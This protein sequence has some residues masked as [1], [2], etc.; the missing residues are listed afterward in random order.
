MQG[1]SST[2]QPENDDSVCDRGHQGA[3][4]GL[5]EV[6]AHAGDIPDIVANVVCDHR[7]ITR[8]ILRNARLDL[9]NQIRPDI[10]GL[11][12]DAATDASEQG[13]RRSAEPDGGNDRH[14]VIAVEH[15]AEEPD[16]EREPEQTETGDRKAHHRPTAER[17]GE[18]QGNAALARRLRGAGIGGGSDPHPDETCQSGEER[19]KH[20]G[21]RT[22]R[23]APR[24]EDDDQ[25]RHQSDEDGDGKVLAAQERHR[26][27]AN[28]A[29]Q[30]DHL[31]V[32]RVGR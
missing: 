24:E 32:S 23:P 8:V 7:R 25:N 28:N 3:H 5:E 4:I 1:E 13:D 22:P 19:P 9:A 31:L 27:L 6:G 10:G 15:I 14:P 26:T 16:A 30:P 17:Y 29:H 11:R 18:G 20:I 12:I 2:R 21:G